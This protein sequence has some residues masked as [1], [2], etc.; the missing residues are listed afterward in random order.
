MCYDLALFS[1]P[2][3]TQYIYDCIVVPKSLS[4]ME[5]KCYNR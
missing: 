3:T 2:M 4:M 5:I 1:G